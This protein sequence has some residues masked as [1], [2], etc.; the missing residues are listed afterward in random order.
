ALLLAPS[1]WAVQ[2]FDPAYR[3]SAMGAVGPSAM[4]RGPG[5]AR[6]GPGRFGWAARTGGWALGQSARGGLRG[7]GRSG[8]VGR[9]GFGGADGNGSLTAD[10][11]RLLDYTRAHQGSATYAFAAGSWSTASPYIL[12]TG[13]HVLPLGGFS[14][15]VPFPTQAQFRRLVDAGKVRYV[16]L[17]GGRGTG[18]GSARTG[19][20]AAAQIT[21]WVRSACTE[22]PASAYGGTTASGDALT[23]TAQALYRCGPGR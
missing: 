15:R 13:A 5:A 4:N 10:Q 3:T 2:V 21:V 16:L 6:S 14:G 1:A 17:G 12:A 8:S 20:T 18:P 9:G 19:N 22:V 23:A 7:F 11:R